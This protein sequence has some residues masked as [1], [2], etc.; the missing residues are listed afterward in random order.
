MATAARN[1]GFIIFALSCSLQSAHAQLDKTFSSIFTEILD[2]RLQRSGSPGQH[3]THFLESAARANNELVPALNSLIAGNISSFPLSSTSSGALFDFSTGEPVPIAESS[4]PIFAET[5][6]PLGKGKLLLDV[7]YTYARLSHLRGIATDDMQFTFTHRDVTNDGTLGQNPNE[8]DLIDLALDLHADLGIGVFFAT[9]G[10]TSNLDVSVAVPV[11]SVRLK[12]TANAT[13]ESYTFGRL[14]HANHLFGGDTLHPALATSVPYNH[15]ATGLGDIALRL[16]Y[17]FT[18]GG[19]FDVAA[20]ADVRFPTGKR[21][22]FLGAGKA[23]FHIWGIL[24]RPF[25]DV[26]PHLNLGYARRQAELQSDVFEF[27]AGFDTKLSSVVT[28][29]MDVLGQLDLDASKAI[30]LA[31]GEVTLSD[32]APGANS[33]RIVQLS[34]VPDRTNDNLVSLST[35]FRFAPSSAWNVFGNVFVPLNEAGLRATVAPTI[36]ISIIL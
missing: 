1:V 24:S 6:K 12:G 15:S 30:H 29:A 14:G 31:P 26:T 11:V 19:S 36:G 4:G 23:T 33:V 35:G 20:L 8:S 2:V 34:N 22:D 21:E 25:G 5:A 3:G 17:C 28:F 32:Q 27:R 7:N 10:V 13:I 18:R 16:K 9:Y